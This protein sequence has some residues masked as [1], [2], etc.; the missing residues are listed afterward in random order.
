VE[1]KYYTIRFRT[2]EIAIDYEKCAHC[3]NYACVKAD[4]LFGTGVLRIQSRKPVL[5]TSPN[6]AKRLCNECLTCELYCQSYGNKGLRIS[7]D[8]FGLDE[9]K[10]R[11]IEKK[12]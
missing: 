4:S 9:Y 3:D 2:G 12:V 8:M 5:A 1:P 10:A 7:L 6:D 11:G